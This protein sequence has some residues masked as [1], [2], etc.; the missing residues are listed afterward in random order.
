MKYTTV[1]SVF[2]TLYKPL[3]SCSHGLN[4]KFTE[5]CNISWEH[6]FNVD[7]VFFQTFYVFKY[8]IHS[9]FMGKMHLDE[10]LFYVKKQKVLHSNW[11]F[12]KNTS[13]ALNFTIR[14]Q[15]RHFFTSSNLSPLRTPLL[16]NDYPPL[17]LWGTLLFPGWEH[18][19][20]VHFSD[21]GRQI[22]LW[23]SWATFSRCTP[24]SCFSAFAWW[25]QSSRWSS[26]H[27]CS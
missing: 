15:M 4:W 1:V 24:L 8:K 26:S 2:C 22:E 27:A 3:F 19:G 12:I 14:V 25:C 5:N 6:R 9:Y 17:T 7:R 20:A 10:F 18:S 23:I 16:W 11:I 13:F 21:F